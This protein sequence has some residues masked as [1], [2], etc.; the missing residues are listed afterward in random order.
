MYLSEIDRQ[1]YEI[2]ILFLVLFVYF[3]QNSLY[4]SSPNMISQL[5]IRDQVWLSNCHADQ[6]LR[7]A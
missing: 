3:F 4:N 1:L 2:C 7:A 6:E 5:D